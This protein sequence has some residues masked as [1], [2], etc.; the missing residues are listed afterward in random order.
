VMVINLG[1]FKRAL[2]VTARDLMQKPFRSGQ[3][4]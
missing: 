4:P 3:G 2:E 1:V